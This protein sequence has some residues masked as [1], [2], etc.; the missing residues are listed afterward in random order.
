M[1]QTIFPKIVATNYSNEAQDIL[2]INFK[3]TDKV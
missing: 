2:E 1:T 3:G